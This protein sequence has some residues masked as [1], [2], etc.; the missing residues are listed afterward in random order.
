MVRASTPAEIADALSRL[1][2][3]LA[4]G[5]RGVAGLRRLSGGATQELWGFEVAGPGAPAA[6]V[7]RRAAPHSLGLGGAGG[8]AVE[9]ELLVAAA[10]AGVPVPT[11]RHILSP[12]DGLGEGF[13]MDHVDGETLGGRIATSPDLEAA[14]ARLTADCAE[15][16]ARLHAIPTDRLP[17]LPVQQPVE[18]LAHWEA[19]YRR[20]G[21]ARPVF[22]L[23]FHHLEG[24]PPRPRAPAL[25]HGDFRNGN[26]MVGPQG[27][28]AV[29]DWELAHLGDPQEDLGWICAPSW[30]FGVLDLPVGGFGAREAFYAAY[31]AAGG[32]AVD[33]EA[34]P[35]WEMV[36]SL[37]WGIMCAGM[38]A[39]FRADDPSV[40][41]AVI[42]RRASETEID[43]LR[44]LDAA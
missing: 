34:A 2:P 7:L 37:R 44:L 27:L 31:E 19:V 5:G 17:V 9:G 16:L 11:V 1:A 43:L 26:L 14:R 21:R 28:R 32:G 23:A 38:A 12:A 24:R 4:P 15:A 6:L 42:A 36:A 29:L 10:G 22:D 8:V 35:W 39:A 40:E 33:R 3:R 13:V 18:L 25:V 30:R 20:T 41:R